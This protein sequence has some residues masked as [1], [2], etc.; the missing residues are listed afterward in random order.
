VESGWLDY[1]KIVVS[2]LILLLSTGAFLA[3]ETKGPEPPGG[4]QDAEVPD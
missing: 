3:E 4:G 1:L 2:L